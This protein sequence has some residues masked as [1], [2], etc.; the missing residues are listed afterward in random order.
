MDRQPAPPDDDVAG[1]FEIRDEQ[2]DVAAIM[3]EIRARLRERRPLDVD[4]DE[5]V[6]R[7]GGS[8]FT[9]LEDEVRY[10]LDQARAAN[11][12]LLVGEQL[13]AQRTRPLDPVRRAFHQLV[14][15]YVDAL[16]QRQR[17]VNADL[18]SAM[19]AVLHR[20]TALAEEQQRTI[21]ALRAELERTRGA[22]DQGGVQRGR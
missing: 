4:L 18:L 3:A 2:I 17:A 10:Y 13:R 12:R 6:F 15:Y 21:A 11:E 20:L 1:V 16:A 9:S 14:Q 19:S 22:G 5:L 7:P 8:A